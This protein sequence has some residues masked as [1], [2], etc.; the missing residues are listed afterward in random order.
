MGCSCK[1]K[2][3]AW[4]SCGESVQFDEPCVPS[5][6]PCPG[7]C[8]IEYGAC[9]AL[10]E[11]YTH[12]D[13]PQACPD[14]TNGAGC[15]IAGPCGPFGPENYPVPTCQY[16]SGLALELQETADELRRMLHEEGFRPYRVCL[17]WTKRNSRQEFVE[18][19]RLELV[20]VKISSLSE[21]SMDLAIF[22]A[23][24]EGSIKVTNVSPHQVDE[25]DLRGLLD[26]RPV[27]HDIQFF[28]EL[29]RIPR[30]QTDGP[31]RRRRFTLGS[32]PNLK[33]LGW[34]FTLVDQEAPRSPRMEDEQMR[35]SKNTDPIKVLRR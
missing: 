3:G 12:L 4:S 1:G 30:C 11:Y 15:V 31:T 20:P 5:P 21:V 24:A 28:Y 27:D 17:I 25:D 10:E 14:K 23:N 13:L 6:D 33:A 9:A 26:H 16:Q 32:L 7:S 34:E 19:R 29:V 8:G 35:P 18:F 2:C 22:G